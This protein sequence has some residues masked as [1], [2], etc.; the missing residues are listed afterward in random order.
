MLGDVGDVA[1][2]IGPRVV[3][4]CVQPRDQ[5]GAGACRRAVGLDRCAG[6]RMKI[7]Q[8][9]GKDRKRDDGKNKTQRPE[10]QAG[11]DAFLFRFLFLTRF[12]FRLFFRLHG[13]SG[14]RCLK[15]PGQLLLV[16]GEHFFRFGGL[17]D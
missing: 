3:E 10:T 9:P 12:F 14:L 2:R 4:P 1:E 11:K 16:R 13:G 15:Y 6:V 17:R 8:G 5:V 7:L